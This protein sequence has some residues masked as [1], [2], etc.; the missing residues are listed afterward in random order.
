MHFF[1]GALRVNKINRTGNSQIFPFFWGGGGGVSQCQ[2]S[3]LF[4][5]ILHVDTKIMG[6]TGCSFVLNDAQDG[7]GVCSNG[8]Y[9]NPSWDG[10]LTGDRG[11]A[12]SSLTGI[13]VLCP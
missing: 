3:I 8:F 1:L 12:G 10:C 4:I 7:L 5:G 11:A 2:L 9:N 6:V 13:T